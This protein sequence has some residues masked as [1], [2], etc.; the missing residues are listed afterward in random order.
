VR[1]TGPAAYYSTESKRGVGVRCGKTKAS[2]LR[3]KRGPVRDGYGAEVADRS[4]LPRPDD[5]HIQAIK[6]VLGL[7]TRQEFQRCRHKDRRRARE[8]DIAEGFTV[9]QIQAGQGNHTKNSHAC[10]DCR[11]RHFAGEGSRGWWYWPPENNKGLKEVGHF[12]VGP[13][14]KH[15]PYAVRGYATAGF[16]RDNYV[17]MIVKQIE[18]AKQEGQ[19][20]ERL[21]GYMLKMEQSAMEAQ[22]RIDCRTSLHAIKMLADET[23]AVLRSSRADPEGTRFFREICDVVGL[24]QEMLSAE[25]R[26]RLLLAA[27]NRPLTELA[28]GRH[29]I[30]SDETSIKLEQ[31]LIKQISDQSKTT[32]DLHEDDFVSKEFMEIL[33]MRFM[34]AV[35]MVYGPKG[36]QEDWEKLVTDFKDIAQAMH[37]ASATI[38]P[39][40]GRKRRGM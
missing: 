3:S 17:E 38:N 6:G 18:M 12:G 27:M 4:A 16:Q 30:M 8:L 36:T 32:F 1:H 29:V 31:S 19:A 13:C 22:E 24:P 20:P 26:D 25:D 37:E 5:K 21:Q 9:A 34:R 39:G 35:E 7:T 28:G 15:G 14:H 33:L 23:I 40:S 2:G 11:C 10:S